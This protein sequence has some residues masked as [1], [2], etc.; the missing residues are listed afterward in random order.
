MRLTARSK[1]L[2]A[3]GPERAAPGDSVTAHRLSLWL[4]QGLLASTLLACQQEAHALHPPPGRPVRE[5]TATPGHAVSPPWPNAN[6]YADN[7]YALSQ[8][9]VWFS[10]F[11]CVGCHGHGGGGI[12]PALM[13]AHW[14]YGSRPE[15]IFTSIAS[16]RPG[17]MPAFGS[18]LLEDQIWQL[19]AFVR[20]LSGWASRA[21]APG[22]EDHMS[23]VKPPNR[24]DP[25]PWT[26][27]EKPTP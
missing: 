27:P 11:N 22:R 25:L 7:G 19:V 14:I 16:G 5:G 6:P 15:E 10:S 9:D 13:D 3:R 20:S 1:A 23:V 17:G 2:E 8:G 18:R 21:E 26:P 4:G 12:G 24:T